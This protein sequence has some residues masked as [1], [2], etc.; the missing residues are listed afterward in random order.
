M[1][2]FTTY[3][4]EVKAIRVKSGSEARH[5]R[6]QNTTIRTPELVQK[7]L[8]QQKLIQNPRKIATTYLN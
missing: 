1:G 6:S 4:E 8:K 7:D 3:R 5:H 2:C